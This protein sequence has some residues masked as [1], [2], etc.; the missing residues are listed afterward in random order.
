MRGVL[1]DIQGIKDKGKL[2]TA[3]SAFWLEFLGDKCPNHLLSTTVFPKEVQPY[4]SQLEGRSMVV[5]KHKIF[6]VEAIV[7]GYITGSAWSEYKK[8]GTVHGI[9]VPEGMQESQKFERPLFTPSTK[10]EMGEHG[11][12]LL[13]DA[14][15]YLN[16]IGRASCR[17]RV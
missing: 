2:L 9:K 14:W 16:Q 1:T 6:P 13:D 17:E 7:R 8:S 3:L 12:F 11:K 4:L 5:K 10:A 15:V